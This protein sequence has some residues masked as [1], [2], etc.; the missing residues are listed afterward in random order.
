MDQFVEHPVL[1]SVTIARIPTLSAVFDDRFCMV[2]SLPSKLVL[3]AFVLLSCAV[4]GSCLL[5]DVLVLRLFPVRLL[6]SLLNEGI[7]GNAC[8]RHSWPGV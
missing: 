8:Y 6:G 2:I 4:C 5:T 7:A 1:R 3:Y